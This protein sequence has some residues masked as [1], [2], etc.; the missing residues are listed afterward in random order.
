MTINGTLRIAVFAGTTTLICVP[1]LTMAAPSIGADCRPKGLVAI[2]QERWNPSGFWQ[3]QLIEIHRRVDGERASYR[4]SVLDRRRDKLQADL[5]TE[6]MRILGISPYRD[7]ALERELASTDREIARFNKKMLDDAVEW[8]R[9][10]SDY[11]AE[12]LRAVT[13]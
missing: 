9:R 12:Q 8:G 4:L 13:R 2:S 5:D 10:C 11:A 3:K 6:E 1:S 7:A